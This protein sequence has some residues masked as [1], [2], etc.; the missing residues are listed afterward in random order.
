MRNRR[1]RRRIR[2]SYLGRRD[3]VFYPVDKRLEVL[4][5]MWP[6]SKSATAAM[7]H[8]GR[9]EQAIECPDC[10]EVGRVVVVAAVV[11]ALVVVVVLVTQGHRSV[12]VDHSAREDQLVVGSDDSE[13]LPTTLHKAVERAKRVG[14]VGDVIGAVLRHLR[15]RQRDSRQRN[16]VP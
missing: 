6:R 4:A 11:I 3:V 10:P 2:T 5:I 16:G 14:D 1:R 13:Q 8:A 12:V 9:T 7:A 15:I